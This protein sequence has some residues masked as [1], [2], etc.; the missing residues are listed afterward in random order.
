MVEPLEL[1]N[2]SNEVTV[3]VI[4]YDC[5]YCNTR[6][7]SEKGWEALDRNQGAP[8][9]HARICPNCKRVTFILNPPPGFMAGGLEDRWEVIGRCRGRWALWRALGPRGDRFGAG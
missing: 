5:G 2:W 8:V 7:S 4:T 6:V 9:A 1:R 3:A